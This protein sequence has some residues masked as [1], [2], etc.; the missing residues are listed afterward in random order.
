MLDPAKGDKRL[1]RKG[2]GK[3]RRKLAEDF[4]SRYTVILPQVR[5]WIAELR[6]PLDE[7]K[8][9]LCEIA[10]LDDEEA[11]ELIENILNENI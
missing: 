10:Q 11:I 8:Q 9:L 7:E 5:D 2:A 6:L 4:P 3:L 1:K